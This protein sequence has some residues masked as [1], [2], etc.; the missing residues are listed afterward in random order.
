M[1][2]ME[3]WR[4]QVEEAVRIH[5]EKI[6]NQNADRLLALIAVAEKAETAGAVLHHCCGS[7]QTYKN[8]A[9]ALRQLEITP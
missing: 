4:E 9:T 5:T 1:T 3:H 8:L 7:T 2:K 6:S